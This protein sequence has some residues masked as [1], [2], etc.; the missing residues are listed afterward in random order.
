MPNAAIFNP[1][2]KFDRGRFWSHARQ[3]LLSHERVSR[4]QQNNAIIVIFVKLHLNTCIDYPW[5][6]NLP[7]L[8]KIVIKNLVG[9]RPAWV[10][11]RGASKEKKFLVQ[12]KNLLVPDD[13]R[14]FFRALQMSELFCLHF[15]LSVHVTLNI[16]IW[17]N[18]P[19]TAMYSFD[20]ASIC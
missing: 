20:Q 4:N 17:K 6:Y 8:L 14:G 1:G 3:P 18:K 19:I 9:E 12:R 16:L 10:L 7:F 15:H 13:R 5:A 11:A 2:K